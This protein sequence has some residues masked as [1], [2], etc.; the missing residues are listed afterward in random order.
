MTSAKQCPLNCTIIMFQVHP[1]KYHSVSICNITT[2][3]HNNI[4]E[5]LDL[6]LELEQNVTKI[7]VII[8]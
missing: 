8:M 1:V 7:S 6:V 3:H 4:L 5:S 2:R